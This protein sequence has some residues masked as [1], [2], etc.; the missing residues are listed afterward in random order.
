MRLKSVYIILLIIISFNA[1]LDLYATSLK[2]KLDS[3][4]AV[5]STQQDDTRKVEIL[6]EIAKAYTKIDMDSARLYANDAFALSNQLG[7]EDGLIGAYYR[8]GYIDKKTGNYKSS[9]NHFTEYMHLSE[10]IGDS[11]NIAKSYLEMG[12]V[13]RR[14][15]SHRLAIY[16]HRLS[17]D[18]Y[19]DLNMPLGIISNYNSMGSLYKQTAQYDSA[20]Y[21]Y[22]QSLNLIK[23]AGL[24]VNFATLYQNLGSLYRI[25][26]DYVNA[27]K[28]L[29]MAIDFVDME[30]GKDKLVDIYMKLGNVASEEMQLDTALH[31]YKM[32]EVIYRELDDQRGIN[33]LYINYG[34]VF[35]N[36]GIMDLAENNFNLA[37]KYYKQQNIPEGIIVAWQDLAS[38][39]TERQE[40]AKALNTL[41]SCLKLSQDTRL[42]RERLSTLLLISD[43]HY[44]MGNYRLSHD[45]YNKHIILK[46]SIYKLKRDEIIA[47]LRIRHFRKLDQAKILALENENLKKTRQ[48]NR[49]MFG[50]VGI[51]SLSIFLI[52]YLR[53]KARKNRIIAEQRIRQ[54]EEEKK[55]LAARFLVEGQEEERKR[56]ATELH[57]GLGVLLSA[58][59]MQF[60]SIKDT[61][62]E[63]KPL[64]EKATKFLE[65][66]S[67]D[68]RKISHNMM[69]GLLTKLGLCEA[70]EDL[71]EKIDESEGVTA[72]CEIKGARERLPENQE[73]MVYRIVQEMVNNTLKHAEASNIKLKI[74]V[75][76]GKL[77]IRYS[78]NGKGFNVEEMLEKK[79]IGLQ[80]I[81]SRVKFLDGSVSIESEAGKGTVYE[82]LIPVTRDL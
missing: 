4:L 65:Q 45:F 34:T 38:I 20:A 50:V 12:N 3:L 21:F 64:I 54:L 36:K 66:A 78:D 60:T 62:P 23:E 40:Y 11:S 68:V 77:D 2:D 46:D 51:I 19:L 30:K 79:S 59:K 58:T 24:E 72:Y 74:D 44:E 22:T 28:Y 63:N 29:E 13:L 32:A 37:L 52:L 8:L 55:L 48:R 67:N 18:I 42:D 17:L 71:F 75:L 26:G 43:I 73:I 31:Y 25:L 47:D 69:P 16:Y 14:L 81:K 49:Y 70:L 76:P 56:I 39:Y 35:K 9:L 15:G 1:T 27:K 82:L 53:L 80:S 5:A 57:D 41:D 6:L 33:D 10:K 7:Y 61:K